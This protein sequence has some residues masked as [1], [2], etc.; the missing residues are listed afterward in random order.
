MKPLEHSQ[1][2]RSLHENRKIAR[3]LLD[4][5]VDQIKNGS[6]SRLAKR[7]ARV[8]RRKAK[9]RSRSAAKYKAN[10][11]EVQKDVDK[12]EHSTAHVDGGVLK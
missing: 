5:K 9:S 10:E 2:T 3:K 7:A 1:Q 8:R 4:L 6:A 12:S 11:L